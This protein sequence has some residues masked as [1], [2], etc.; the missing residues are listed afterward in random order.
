MALECIDV[1]MEFSSQVNLQHTVLLFAMASFFGSWAS[2]LHY[3][4]D[5]KAN[6]ITLTQYFVILTLMQLPDFCF[7]IL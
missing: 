1:I 4:T 6:F 5:D 7:L 3:T 2:K